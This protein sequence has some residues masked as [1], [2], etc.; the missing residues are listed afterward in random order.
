MSE[1]THTN[2]SLIPRRIAYKYLLGKKPRPKM[3]RRGLVRQAKQLHHK[4]YTSFFNR[5]LLALEDFCCEGLVS[6]FR[7]RMSGLRPGVK[8][9]WSITDYTSRPK[10][11]AN[12]ATYIPVPGAEKVGIR[13]VTVRIDSKQRVDTIT[14]DWRGVEQRQEG[15]PKQ[16]REFTVMQRRLINNEESHWVLWGTVQESSAEVDDE[17]TGELD[18]Q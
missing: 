3:T 5:D 18:S 10:I 4:M 14:K 2:L 15:L 12:C 17:A 1:R 6:S 9:E 7:T 16:V 8:H 11:V 13:Q